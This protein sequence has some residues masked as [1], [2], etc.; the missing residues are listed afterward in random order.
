MWQNLLTLETSQRW[1]PSGCCELSKP[2][3]LSQVRHLTQSSDPLYSYEFQKSTMF[4]P[5]LRSGL[6]TIVGALIQSV[7]KLADVMILT[8]FCLSVF[9]LIGLQLFMGLL[10]Q[11]CVRSLAHCINSSYSSNA[12]FTCNNRTWSSRADFLTSEGQPKEKIRGPGATTA[13]YTS[14]REKTWLFV[15]VPFLSPQIISTKWKEQRTP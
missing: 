6:K 8:V 14:L 12:S 1:E 5:P 4:S 3:Q 7:R 2:S 15:S 11:K 10:R 13:F 9:A